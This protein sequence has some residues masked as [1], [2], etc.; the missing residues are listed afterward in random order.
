MSGNYVSM[1]SD[2][3]SPMSILMASRMRKLY[4]IKG[5]SPQP[6]ISPYLT[7]KTNLE[8]GR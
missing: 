2:R 6:D 3:T 7:Q 5:K 8:I 1:L 4:E